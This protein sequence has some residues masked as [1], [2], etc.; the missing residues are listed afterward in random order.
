MTILDS[1]VDG[2]REQNT[3]LHDR[4]ELAEETL[5]AI[6]SGEV[7]AIAVETPAGV[8]VF[9]LGGADQQYRMMVET[10]SE[11]AVTVTP[12][13]VILFCNQR[14]VDMAKAGLD[15][16]IGSYLLGHFAD[17]DQAK[18]AAAMSESQSGIPRVRAT[19]LA[20]DGTRVPVNVAM[21][22]QTQSKTQS[23]ATVVTD[24]TAWQ[25]MEAARE[26]ATRSLHMINAC[27]EIIIRVTDE[28]RMLADMCQTM[29]DVGGYKLVWV[30]YAEHDE[31]KSVRPVA[32]AGN[33]D[34]Y[35][36]NAKITWADTER[37]RGPTGT[38]IRTGRSII[39]RDTET[40]P[41]YEPWRRMAEERGFRSSATFPLRADH[42]VFGALMI[43]SARP[44]GFDEEESRLL[45]E[46]AGNLEFGIVALRNKLS[47]LQHRQH[48]EELVATRTND[49]ER[50]IG[51]LT[52]AN[53]ELETFAYSVSHDLR[54]PL[55][56][57][58]GFSNILLKDYA[59]KLDAEGRRLLQVVRDGATRMGH[60]I[61]D[62]LAFSRIGRQQLT[63]S[64]TDMGKLVQDSL[65]ELAPAM[66]DR[67]IEV[68]VGAL[69][70]VHGDP[71]MLQ[72]VWTNL[73]DNAIKYTGLKPNA[74]IEVGSFAE[75][76]ETVFFVKDN[77]A[78]F[79]MQYA[80]KLFGMF[81]RL[82]SS[83]QFP[84]TGI[85]LAVIKRIIT[86]HGGRVW[87][88]GKVGEGA[89]FYVALPQAGVGH[90]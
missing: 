35:V 28:G 20:S 46:L 54:T 27:N 12:D 45:A 4:L 5:R 23:V 82:H 72:R 36:E 11:G 3:A 51:G 74:V 53:Q 81:Q 24:L 14:F 15:M 9:T 42:D 33:S 77:G 48:L 22:S 66:A 40:E 57:I 67:P 73:L 65:R 37:G 80:E 60:L 89:T 76:S 58:D 2:L 19:L 63:A 84:G 70:H 13:G 56:A 49:L 79:D 31:A 44:D 43:Y 59:D 62:I 32:Q 78:G 87:A 52:A 55:R 10:M 17:D 7:D 50:A 75:G 47:L 30:G 21:H 18:I 85:G 1:T 41:H 25:S 90:A 86:R 38:A 29:V 34:D 64:D 16:I 68:I 39:A 26:R 6:R 83:E 61:D 88:E 69:P 71:Q 8:R